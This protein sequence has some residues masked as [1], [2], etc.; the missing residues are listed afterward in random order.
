MSSSIGSKI[1]IKRGAFIGNNSSLK[2]NIIIGEWA[3]IGMGSVV[4]KSVRDNTTI[5]GNPGKKL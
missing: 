1:K 5:V 3:T 2:E 4:L